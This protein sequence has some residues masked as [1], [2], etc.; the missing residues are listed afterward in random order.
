MSVQYL[1]QENNF[2]L[3]SKN[4]TLENDLQVNN[5]V[6]V[7]GDVT[8]NSFVGPLI[9]LGPV[10]FPS[11]AGSTGY[12]DHHASVSTHGGLSVEKNMNAKQ[13]W[14]NSLNN[15]DF[16]PLASCDD[17]IVGNTGDI[18][19]GISIWVPDLPGNTAQLCFGESLTS[20]VNGGIQYVHQGVTGDQLSL[21]CGNA[22]LVQLQN[23]TTLPFIV[24]NEELKLVKTTNQIKAELTNDSVLNFVDPAADQVLNIPDSGALSADFVLTEGAQTI[25]GVKRFGD[26]IVC[27]PAND[28][29]V[30]DG[31]AFATI[32]NVPVPGQF[33]T[34][35]IQD[36]GMAASNILLSEGAQTKN[37][38]LTLT[39][40][41]V[42]S[43]A[44]SNNQILFGPNPGT[45]TTLNVPLPLADRVVTIPDALADANFVLSEGDATINGVKTFGNQV[46]IDEASNQLVFDTGANN[47]TFN[48]AAPAA[49]QTYIFPDSG[50]A[51]TNV[52]YSSGNSQAISS[53]KTFSAQTT[54][55][56][57]T[58]SPSNQGYLYS[59][60]SDASGGTPQ[61][62]NQRVGSVSFT[63]IA[64]TASQGAVTL[65][66]TNSLVTASTRGQVTVVG[67][68]IAANSCFVLKSFA[69]S[70][71]T[72]TCVIFNASTT[73]SGAAGVVTLAFQL[74]N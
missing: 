67:Q 18:N 3:Y 49:G 72:I 25:N 17:L 55:L 50:T 41:L 69:F 19:Q 29:I 23:D 13:I 61:I 65:V 12:A 54:F 2:H 16:T 51:S 38:S 47:V 59:A 4:L 34:V 9:P 42:L 52:V 40:Q 60:I 28:Q 22:V 6:N 62:L 33:T 11:T 26:N 7:V 30:F 46:I 32:L 27:D 66:I 64:D 37:G 8:A 70:A 5:N 45:N 39:N 15:N 31:G 1:L 53:A 74:W 20:T 43:L 10:D 21:I 44:P 56:L 73:T 57:G 63:G 48:V 71:N 68:A 24:M 14:V 35:S 58:T 36:S